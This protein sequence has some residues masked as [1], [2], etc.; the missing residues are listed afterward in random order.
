MWY[1]HGLPA[2]HHGD[3]CDLR[4]PATE[5]SL[6]LTH[7]LRHTRMFPTSGSHLVHLERQKR[8]CPELMQRLIAAPLGR[9]GIGGATTCLSN[10]QAKSQQMEWEKINR[11]L[12]IMVPSPG[13]VR[14]TVMTNR[15]EIERLIKECDLRWTAETSGDCVMCVGKNACF[16]DKLFY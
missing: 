7:K 9:V 10:K 6:A 16:V 15:L 13:T 5:W 8:L 14:F 12:F 1:V 4:S 3:M 11:W 2:H